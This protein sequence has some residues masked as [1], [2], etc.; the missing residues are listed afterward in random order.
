[1][2]MIPSLPDLDLSLSIDCG[3]N[4]I[5]SLFQTVLRVKV[6]SVVTSLGHFH[7]GDNNPVK[8][9]YTEAF[10]VN[11]YNRIDLASAFHQSCL[12]G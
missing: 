8:M 6:V 7:F 5:A 4:I 11:V 1:M 3:I 12:I 2:D 10:R 9:F